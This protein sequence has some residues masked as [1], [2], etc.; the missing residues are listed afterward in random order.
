ML[1]PDLSSQSSDNTDRFLRRTSSYGGRKLNWQAI[2]MDIYK[3][4]FCITDLYLL[5]VTCSLLL[6]LTTTY[7]FPVTGSL[8]PLLTTINPLSITGLNQIRI[9]A[10]IRFLITTIFHETLS[11]Y[12]T[13]HK[14]LSP[15]AEWSSGGMERLL[16]QDTILGVVG[17]PR[18]CRQENNSYIERRG[19]ACVSAWG[20]KRGGAASPRCAA[21][22]NLVQNEAD[23][24]RSSFPIRG[25]RGEY[26]RV[27]GSEFPPRAK[28]GVRGGNAASAGAEYAPRL[29]VTPFPLEIQVI[30]QFI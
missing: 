6:L 28:W 29:L 30:H 17:A 9:T 10:R 15:C 26:F 21:A 18:L 20:D 7:S 19:C 8:L 4:L 2:R 5:S 22:H 23:N 24:N 16:A 12:E 14:R 13:F 11:Q 27:G 3:M 25:A 1:G